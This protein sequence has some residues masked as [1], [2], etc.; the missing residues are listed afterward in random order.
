MSWKSIRL[1]LLACLAV[2]SIAA[3]IL[4]S[5]GLLFKNENSLPEPKLATIN[6]IDSTPEPTSSPTAK[7]ILTN[8]KPKTTPTPAA[9]TA[10]NAPSS[11]NQSNS[12]DNNTGG[13]QVSNPTTNPTTAPTQKPATITPAPTAIPIV[14]PT[15]E[16]ANIQVWVRGWK[17]SSTGHQYSADGSIKIF[18]GG[19]EVASGFYNSYQDPYKA[20][21]L[22]TNANL[23]VYFY[24]SGCGQVKNVSTGNASS[25]YQLDFHFSNTTTCL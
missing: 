19:T 1:P 4:D 3:A 13:N 14:A 25:L 21:N 6:E 2:L 5:K 15:Q 17:Y 22:P 8:T 9:I 10:T 7:S 24:M 12:N 20:T 11:G 16:P 23:S 18:N